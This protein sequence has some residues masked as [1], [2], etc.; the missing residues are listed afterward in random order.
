MTTSGLN[1]DMNIHFR[2]TM[3]HHNVVLPAKAEG[4]VG[5]GGLS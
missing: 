5:K 4:V 1:H 3:L 2:C